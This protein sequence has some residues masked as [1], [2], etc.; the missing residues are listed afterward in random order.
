MK[1]Q[2]SNS[3]TDTSKVRKKE[4]RKKKFINLCDKRTCRFGIL[5]N[6]Y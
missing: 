1:K 5:E 4:H 2:F 6:A 3:Y